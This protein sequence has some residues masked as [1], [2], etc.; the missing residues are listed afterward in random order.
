MRRTVSVIAKMQDHLHYK[1]QHNT[2]LQMRLWSQKSQQQR[3][4]KW[5]TTL[6]SR[7]QKHAQ[8]YATDRMATQKLFAI[9]QRQAMFFCLDGT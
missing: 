1:H 6:S 7:C 9:P 8:I 4:N 2:L 3:E 5:R